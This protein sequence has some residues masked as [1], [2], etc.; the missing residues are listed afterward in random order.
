MIRIRLSVGR[1]GPGGTYR[2]GD[3]L[4]VPDDEAR[5][6]VDT[7]QAETVVG[8]ESATVTPPQDAARRPRGRP[9]KRYGTSPKNRAD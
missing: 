2:P 5:R 9:R 6:L 1:V 8:P 3:E 7:L 4:D